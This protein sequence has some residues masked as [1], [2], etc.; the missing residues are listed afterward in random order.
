[1]TATLA[2][3]PPGPSRALARPAILAGLE[4][5]GAPLYRYQIDAAAAL[6]EPGDTPGELKYPTAVILWP[7][8]TGKTTLLLTLAL[9]RALYQQR[10]AAAYMAQTGHVTSQR[11]KDWNQAI[12]RTPDWHRRYQTFDSEGR[13]RITVLATSSYLRAAVP[14]PGRLRSSALDLVIVDEAQEHDDLKV[15][16]P[17]DAGIIPTMDTRAGAQWII[18]GTAGDAAAT[19]FRR[20]YRR[21][22]EGA[23]GTLLLELGTWPEDADP[24]DPATWQAHHPGLIAGSTT[25]A[26]LDRAR[27]TLGTERFAREYGNRWTDAIAESVFPPGAWAACHSPNAAI[28]GPV[29]LALEVPPARDH[30]VIIAAGASTA[31]PG[32]VH[33]EL[34]AMLPLPLAVAAA[35]KLTD[36]HRTPLWIDK[37]SPAGNMI[38]ALTAGGVHLHHV[39]FPEL[40]EASLT[41]YDRV[42]EHTITHLAQPPL[43]TAAAA[44]SKRKLGARWAFDRYAP[45]GALIVAASLAALDADRRLRGNTAARPALITAEK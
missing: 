41:L 15:G 29:S 44:A 16:Q 35:R 33:V 31:H 25:V 2:D 6:S 11:F 39:T 37:M 40:V 28:T 22:L 17:L 34:A 27:E 38:D 20:H 3:A 12:R 32:T 19:Y 26:K 5:I 8:Q 9:G 42:R 24:D 18:A 30:A 21:A 23:P 45:N 36:Q 4:L 1:M 43:T 14:I 13:E 10:M 7:R